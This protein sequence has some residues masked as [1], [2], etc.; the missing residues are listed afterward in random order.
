MERMIT[1][2][3]IGKNNRAKIEIYQMVY[4]LYGLG[5]SRLRLWR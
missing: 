2:F 4:E 3:N 5:E 1:L